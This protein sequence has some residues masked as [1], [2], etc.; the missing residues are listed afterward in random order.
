M[1]QPSSKL[2]TIP[3]TSIDPGTRYRKD[4]GDISEMCFSIQ[5]HGQISPITVSLN[6]KPNSTQPYLLAAGGRRLNAFTKLAETDDK[7]LT[8]DAK[9]FEKILTELELRNI[10]LCE[11]IHRKDFDYAEKLKITAEVQRL[12]EKIHG[13]KVA[14]TPD[15][16]GWSQADTAKLLGKSPASVA[17]DLKLAKAI[18]MVPELANCKN[19]NDAMKKLRNMEKTIINNKLSKD[20]EAAAKNSGGVAHQLINS[21]IVGDFFEKVKKIPDNSINFCEIDPPYAIDLNARKKDNPYLHK[22]YNEIDY[23]E[24]SEFLQQTFKECYRVLAPNSWLICWFGPE[25]WLETVH[26]LLI[27]A[28]FTTHRMCGIWNKGVGQTMSPKTRLANSYE[29]FYYA[30]KGNPNIKKMGHN[31]IFDYSPVPPSEKYHPT[32]RPNNLIKELLFTFANPDDNILV[33]Y[34]GSGQ[35]I[36]SAHECRMK[37]YG[38]DLSPDYKNEFTIRVQEGVK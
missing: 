22:T 30:A 34:L 11:N 12:N 31:N 4:Y 20:Y 19:K 29:M 25:P 14:K 24:Y 8:I 10:E 33:P 1:T 7:Y 2:L 13:K 37:A 9:V 16:A 32:Q 5:K 18:E 26:S 15:A 28:G 3:I 23:H 21:Y 35:T 38:F 17:Q 36:L 27:E 6:P